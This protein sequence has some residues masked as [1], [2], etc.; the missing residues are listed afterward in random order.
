MAENL[1]TS[2]E[3]NSWTVRLLLTDEGFTLPTDVEVVAPDGRSWAGTVATLSMIESI[4]E[5]YRS[6]GECLSGAYF[7]MADLLLVKDSLQT[8]VVDSVLDLAATGEIDACFES[9][10]ADR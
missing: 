3:R 1:W 2:F 4:M 7:W 10:S 5:S 9:V 8:T 6:S